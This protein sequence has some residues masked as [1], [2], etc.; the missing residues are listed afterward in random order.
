MCV[1]QVES[2]RSTCTLTEMV[3]NGKDIEL[4]L[5]KKDVQDKLTALGDIDVKVLPETVQKQIEFVPGTVDFGRLH[6][7]D[8][9]TMRMREGPDQAKRAAVARATQTDA[10]SGRRAGFREIATQTDN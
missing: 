2:L 8:R 3:L 7:R 1:L 5:L 9:P 10:D 4:L 6:D